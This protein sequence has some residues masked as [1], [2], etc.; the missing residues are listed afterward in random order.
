MSYQV[1]ARKWRPDQFSDVV[2][3]EHIIAAL[4][5]ALNNQRLHHA[6]LFSGTR[7]VGK[8]S[9]ARLFAKGLNCEKGITATPCGECENCR[10][11]KEGNFI[12]LIEIDAASRT[13]VEDTRELLDN[14]QYKPVRGRFKI[15]LIDEVHMLSR[16]SFNALLKTLE[17]P[18]EYVK[19]LLATTDPQKL[20]ITVLSRCIQFHLKALDADVIAAHLQKL[21]QKEHIDYQLQALMKI[22]RAAQGSVRDALSLTD[23]AI[24]LSNSNINVNDVNMMLG[25]LDNDKSIALLKALSQADGEQA[26]QVLYEIA[27][28]GVDWERVLQ[29]M[30]ETLHQIAMLQFLP[31]NPE[32]ANT[33]LTLLAKNLSP[34]DVQ[35]YYELMVK[36]REELSYSPDPKIG[37]EMTMLRALA[38]HPKRFF[39]PNEMAVVSHTEITSEKSE[40]S[41]FSV[42]HS[43][44]QS[45]SN[46]V[47]ITPVNRETTGSSWKQVV[48]PQIDSN[49]AT[50]PADSNQ[51]QS[52]K[53]SAQQSLSILQAVSN[54]EQ[55][56]TA[57]MVLD[58]KNVVE[59]EKKKFDL[60][61]DR[62][63]RSVNEVPPSISRK[64]NS[65]PE[66]RELITNDYAH[67][68]DVAESSS[69]LWEKASATETNDEEESENESINEDYHWSWSDPSLALQGQAVKP[70]E[71]KQTLL[72]RYTPEVLEQIIALTA[73][74][75]E[76]SSDIEKMAVKGNSKGI[77]LKSVILEKTDDFLKL[78]LRPEAFN[79][80]K[81]LDSAFITQALKD[82]YG[83]Q[84]RIELDV[85]QGEQ[86]TPFEIRN[87]IYQQL[88]V[89][90]QQNLQQDRVLQ[91]FMQQFD[92]QITLDSVRPTGKT[93]H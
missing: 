79:L 14:V 52:I 89:Q 59:S 78:G 23:Q 19:F 4:T 13:K 29:E 77:L 8:T 27:Q 65:E 72:K 48:Q 24:A 93:G 75:S 31:P 76:W 40:K 74:Q 28:Q 60:V 61:E 7:G 21:L 33:A 43:L 54:L 20:P 85:Y 82:F 9:I 12:D 70:S 87:E 16:H 69:S 2:G 88:V 26:M 62:A 71:I 10:A 34:E 49:E 18:P 53:S 90:A 47:Q 81:T 45:T 32:Q 37:V 64:Q 56:Q 63:I 22:A 92:A 86:K 3:Q 44:Q 46:D 25:L 30:A 55:G 11:I 84:M 50:I 67:N 15:Y 38:F 1:L 91:D 41:P 39:L 83:H 58:N 51:Q 68:I 42:Q 5:N 35:F 57:H 6:Y 36:G 66:N 80:L 73:K 17:E